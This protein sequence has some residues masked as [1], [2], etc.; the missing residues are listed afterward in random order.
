MTNLEIRAVRAA[1]SS[2]GTG[3]TRT[4]PVDV[5]LDVSGQRVFDGVHQRAAGTGYLPF[6]YDIHGV[7]TIGSKVRLRELENFR[8]A[9][10]G[11]NYDIAVRVGSIG[12]GRIHRRAQVIRSAHP[13]VIRYEEQLGRLGANFV[14]ELGD[15]VAVTVSPFLARSPHV[16]YTNVVE[17]LLRFVL[18]AR[19]CMLL[20]SACIELDGHGLLLSARTDTGK[21]GSVLRLLREQPTRFLSDDMTILQ[22]DA[23][24]WSFP[25]PL[26]ISQHTL[27]AVDPGDLTS[28][29]WLAL[30]FKGRLHSKEGRSLGMRLGQLNV[31]IMA[32]NSLTQMIVPPPKYHADRL[33]ACETTNRTDV[34]DLFII[35]RGA[36]ACV[37]LSVE[38]A[39]D[40]LLVNTD[41]AYGF[42][43]FRY[44]AP[45]IVLDGADYEELRVQERKILTSAVTLM[46]TRRLASDTFGW[47]DEIPALLR[48]VPR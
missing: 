44:F 32:L 21:T 38:E 6:R 47:A 48:G 4:D 2:D 42:P 29:E 36:P 11:N 17:A 24:A 3:S 40:E 14:V 5:H 8:S 1:T 34:R 10:V 41:D 26:T 30:R 46:R 37:P 18:A 7:V 35:E 22:P 19:G 16:L 27:R 9:A 45:A 20:H 28:A 25:K 43:P 15:K 12:S 31:P 33:V 39:V 13:A 23:T